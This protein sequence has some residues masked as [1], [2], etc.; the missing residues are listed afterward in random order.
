MFQYEQHFSVMNRVNQNYTETL[1]YH[2]GIFFDTPHDSEVGSVYSCLQVYCNYTDIFA[3]A[4]II[5]IVD[6]AI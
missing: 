5:K 1:S 6:G 4:F 3:V 2:P